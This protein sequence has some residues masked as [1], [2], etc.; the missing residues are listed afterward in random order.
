M[1]GYQPDVYA[2]ISITFAVAAV[3]LGCRLAARRMTKQRYWFDDYFAV[4]AFVRRD[5]LSFLSLS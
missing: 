3:A 4:I 5:K 2:S 1:A